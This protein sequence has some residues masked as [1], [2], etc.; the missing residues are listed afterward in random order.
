MQKLRRGRVSSFE[1]VSEGGALTTLGAVAAIIL[2]FLCG[3]ILVRITSTTE[4]GLVALAYIMVSLL[5]LLGSLGFRNGV[6][7]FLAVHRKDTAEPFGKNIIATALTAGVLA[8]GLLT[9]VTL[10]IASSLESALNQPELRQS[11]SILS[12]MILP[13]VATNILTAVHRGFENVQA[14]LLFQDVSPNLF[15]AGLLLL[16]LVLGLGYREA[17]WAY[18]A[19]VW[20]SLGL[21]L[22]YTGRMWRR[23]FLGVVDVTTGKALLRFS[24]PLAVSELLTNIVHWAG[25]LALGIWHSSDQVAHFSVA[26]RVATL[27]GIP[28]VAMS[29]LY[30]P[31]SSALHSPGSK[32]E[33]TNLYL[34]TAKIAF[35]VTAPVALYLLFNGEALLSAIF[36]KEYSAAGD[37]LRFLCLGFAVHT[38]F[39]LNGI[40]LV[41]LGDSSKVLRASIISALILG[42]LCV[43]LVPHY[44]SP[45]AALATAAAMLAS[46]CYL[47]IELH[48]R[49]GIHFLHSHYL[50]P[51]ALMV[52]V[53]GA[54]FALLRGAQIENISWHFAVFLAAAIF[55][56]AAPSLTGNLTVADRELLKAL[57]YSGRRIAPNRRP[58]PGPESN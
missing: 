24:L 48:R 22:V 7:Y 53:C 41:S 8:A 3:L 26:I 58:L 51:A 40:T 28:L 32:K 43:L 34:S 38:F 11:L 47:S 12:L 13:V 50:K 23:D 5:S 15:R 55:S 27:M 30:L 36:G 2:Q 35:H 20:I 19:S 6:T 37:A 25:V 56:L 46:N 16:L 45:G 49:T 10:G 52:A 1:K 31:V 42:F 18:V 33:R 44:A 21:Y 14:K 54:A 39:G 17:L 4:F 29:F 9:I 57:K